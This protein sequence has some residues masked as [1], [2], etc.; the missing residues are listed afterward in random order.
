MRRVCSIFVISILLLFAFYKD[1][2]A[3]AMRDYCVIPP[4][5]TLNP[6]KTNVL[7]IFDNSN[8]MD[9][10]FYGNAV[11]S[12]SPASKSVVG[13]KALREIVERFKDKFRIGLITYKVSG[14]RA[15]HIHNSSYF[16]SYE[17]KSYCPNP[18]PECVEYCQTGNAEAKSICESQ[19]QADNPFF[20]VDYFDEII[21]NYSIGSEQR[22]R[23]CSLVYPK[24]QRMVNPTDPSHYMYYKHAYPMYSSSNLANAFCYST[25]YNPN[26]GSPYDSYYCYHTKTGTSDDY[27][28]YSNYW[29]YAQF[30]PTDTDYALGYYDFGRRLSLSLIHI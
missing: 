14:V 22:N 26:E 10:D 15:Y 2:P 1:S 27:N 13:K 12:Y 29:F 18:P 24:T 20:D 23:Y 28:G 30:I 19:C 7:I 17:P 3:T 9:E 25:G 4:F 21:T 6:P 16:V 5:V 11:G 8:S